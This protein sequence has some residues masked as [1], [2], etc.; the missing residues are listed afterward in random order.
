MARL[1][2]T[3][4]ETRYHHPA[5]M[6]WA[7]EMHL[8]NAMDTEQTATRLQEATEVEA[9]QMVLTEAEA[10]SSTAEVVSI[11]RCVGVMDRQEDK[12]EDHR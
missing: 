2:E 1:E 6:E 4:M 3:S 9:D 12:V 5:N 7:V 11:L 8:E 10:A